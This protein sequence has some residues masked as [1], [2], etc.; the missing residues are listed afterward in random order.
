MSSKR[1]PDPGATE[2]QRRHYPGFDGTVRTTFAASE[3]SWP[4]RPSPPAGAPNVIVMLADDLGFSDLE[5]YGSEIE[6]PN[7]NALAQRGFRLTDFHSTPLCGPSRAALLTGLNPHEAG[8]GYIN[9]ADPGFPGYA[10]ELPDDA[11]SAAEIFRANGYATF[12]LG[13]WHLTKES[14]LNAGGSNRSW[15]LRRGFDRFY[16]FLDGFTNAHAPHSLMSDN[17][18]VEVDAYDDSY[19]LTDD[20]TSQGIAMIRELKSANPHK[21][22][23]MYY[24]H[25]AVHA[26]LH[27]K[28]AEIERHRGRYDD[29]W[30]VVR[31]RRFARQ[32]DM[33]VVP[34]HTRLSDRNAEPGLSVQPWTEL[35]RAQQ[36]RYSRYMETYA[37][38]VSSI[39]D[40]VGQLMAT[41]DELG[42]ADETIIVF[43]SDNGGAKTGGTDGT[44]QYLETVL[45][46]L[47][48]DEDHHEADDEVALDAIGGPSTMPCYP[49][50]WAMVSNTPYRLYKA[51]THA[52]GHAVPF[53]MS[54]PMVREPGV[55]RRQYTHIADVLPSLVD[56][57]GLELP[58]HRE[59]VPARSMSGISFAPILRNPIAPATRQEQY[60]EIGGHRGIYRDGWEAVTLHRPDVAF[61]AEAWE[62]FD[63]EADPAQTRDLA[64]SHPE[65]LAELVAAWEDLAWRNRVFPMDEGSGVMR[66]LGPPGNSTFSEPLEI[67]GGTP[68]LE[69]WRS[70]QLIEQRDF[71]IA[72]SFRHE[73]GDAGVL[74][75]HGGQG[76]GYILYVEDGFVLYGHNAYGRVTIHRGPRVSD[77]DHRVRLD[78]VVPAPGRWELTLAL[79]DHAWVEQLTTTMIGP[80]VA[81][82][83]GID[84]GIDR[85]SPVLQSLRD[86]YGAFPYSGT[87]R[88]ARYEPGPRTP[89]WGADALDRARQIGLQFE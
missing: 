41:L 64:S 38:M 40:S 75:A 34:P 88:W 37:A 22:F 5:C 63:V 35:T 67:T 6:T 36:L 89:D 68:T 84:V 13:K 25:A 31:E 10:A 56:E 29:G 86:R 20:L 46:Y 2:R 15:P 11:L 85:R 3:P 43:C 53:I 87:V 61:S 17:H 18:V 71:S 83:E 58:A 66:R 19:Y 60:Y 52:G 69:R 23:F 74:L 77:G 48:I 8:C 45:H 49:T 70:R 27:A 80:G 82:L 32:V 4:E 73:C 62:L 59:G 9:I 12:A 76:G 44:D 42:I 72:V 47:G 28:S 54:G 51:H 16:G 33:G 26:P 1:R 39:D 65:R 57:I 79:D 7:L 81:P 78:A 24:A 30:D 50:G 55:L 14:D 21:P